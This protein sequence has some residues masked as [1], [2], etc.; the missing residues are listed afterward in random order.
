MDS[1]GLDS[2]RFDRR[3]WTRDGNINSK[4][5]LYVNSFSPE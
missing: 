2:I 1:I 3:R 4:V 5:R